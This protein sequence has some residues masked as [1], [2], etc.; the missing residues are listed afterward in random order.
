MGRAVVALGVF[1]LFAAVVAGADAR[2]GSAA[3]S[4]PKVRVVQISYRAHNGV[5]TAAT[6]VVPARYGRGRPS[7]PLPLVISPHGRGLT[8]RQNARLWGRLPA[9]GGFAVVSPDGQGR[10]LPRH[11]WGFAGQISDLARMPSI[12]RRA[13]PWLRIDRRRIYAFG[14]SMGGQETLLLVARH[15]RLL[16]GAAAFDPVTDF[17]Q[18]YRSW[19]G[20]GCNSLCRHRLNGGRLGWRLQYLARRE[21][22]GTLTTTPGAFARRS[23]AAYARRIAWSCVPLQLW[24]SV[25][26]RVVRNEQRQSAA[27]LRRVRA[28]N[29]HPPVHDPHCR[30]ARIDAAPARARDVRPPP[31]GRR[32][33][34]PHDRGS[35]AGCRPLRRDRPR[36]LTRF[37][38]L[39]GVSTDR[40]EHLTQ[41]QKDQLETELAELEGPA[42]T[43]AIEA[44]AVARSYGD[45]SENFEYHAAK[46]AQGLLERRITMLRDRL[47]RAVL[48]DEDANA[49]VVGVGSRVEIEDEGG[50]RMEVEISSVGG[51]SP[52][53]PLGRALIGAKVGDEVAVEAPRGS[54][55]ARVLSITR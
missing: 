15:P 30:D 53:S 45:L 10:V 38:T 29:N 20:V 37:R 8:G 22:G 28:M 21:V 55:R 14:G 34:R 44:I 26:D 18:Q 33:D 43:A 51:V 54:W 7:P 42:R 41:A 48:V 3:R 25:S 35:A 6:V 50:E 24:W 31:V 12:V 11:S 2:S 5:R 17:A 13:V 47:S 9:V 39:P 1:A 19:P 49:D 16:A 36:P 46:D 27:L 32:A 52:E 4:A 40:P 23:P